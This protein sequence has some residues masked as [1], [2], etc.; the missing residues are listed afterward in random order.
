MNWLEENEEDNDYIF[1]PPS[2]RQFDLVGETKAIQ[3]VEKAISICENDK[4]RYPEMDGKYLKQ[5]QKNKI[6]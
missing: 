4:T 1:K 6:L 3:L 2:L 5:L